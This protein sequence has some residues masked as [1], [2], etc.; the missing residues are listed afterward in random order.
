MQG[1]RPE[2]KPSNDENQNKYCDRFSLKYRTAIVTLTKCFYVYNVEVYLIWF[3]LYLRKE[4][5]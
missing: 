1:K 2:Q 5:K 4:N 3:L